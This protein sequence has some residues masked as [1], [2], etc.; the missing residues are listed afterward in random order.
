MAIYERLTATDATKLPVHAFSA[1]CH[2]YLVGSITLQQF[3]DRLVLESGDQTE[4][5]AIKTAYDGLGAAGKAEFATRVHAVFLL[6]EA[7][8]VTKNEAKALLGF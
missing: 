8:H 5:Q 4:V 2:L 7:G 1:G 6:A 3:A